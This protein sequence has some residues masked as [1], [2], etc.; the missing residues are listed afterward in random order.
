M[1][2]LRVRLVVLWLLSLAVSVAAAL[3]LVR[4]STQSV[5]A[6]VA[7]GEAIVARAC[8]L[9]R[10]RY[11]FYST[12]W[13]GPVPPPDDPAL[14]Q[15]LGAVVAVALARQP[16]VAGGVW[17]SEAGP[18]TA[19]RLPR[20]RPRAWGER[21]LRARAEGTPAADPASGVSAGDAAA[22]GT[23]AGNTAAGDVPGGPA[24][25]AAGAPP[26][27]GTGT[28]L[29]EAWL[30]SAA[31][32]AL[33]EDTTVARSWRA[34]GATRLLAACPLPGPI[35]G[36]TAW[37]LTDAEGVEAD[38]GLQ[39]GLAALLAVMLLLSVW[40]FWLLRDWS[41]RVG[42]VEAALTAGDDRLALPLPGE[43]DLDRIV[44]ALNR[45]G[46]RL[47]EARARSEALRRQVAESERL[48]ALGRVA[49]GLAH[50]IR[51][52]LAAMRLKAE[53][54]LAG[55]EARRV[56]ALGDVLAQVGRL[57][58]LLR[59]LLAM[60]QRHEPVPEIVQLD[61]L[62]ASCAEAHAE[63]AA[64]AGVALRHEGSGTAR[65]DPA[66]LRRAV[67]S[68]LD[69]AVRHTAVGGT[70]SL[71]AGWRDGTLAIAVE[72]TVAPGA[73]GV[74][75]SL[76]D[77]LFEPFVTGRP[78]GTGLGLAIA[79]ELVAAQRG[80]LLLDDPGGAGHPTRFLILLPEATTPSPTPSPDTAAWP[81]S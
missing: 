21:W 17:Q 6:Q 10:D 72:N 66:L 77:T 50:E 15:S 67:D 62:L 70:V 46:A 19:I 78:E 32:A 4:A 75:P 60:T 61:A 29:T 73:P 35:T 31:G 51:N 27:D 41:R 45:A 8:D 24:G 74:D 20:R 58:T 1:N 59:E 7:R 76:R 81:P 48:A 44:G 68:L 9:I 52:P 63:R 54:A 14:Q 38:H 37:A 26:T 3:L 64:A 18:L 34:D 42:R 33:R 23:P 2:A 53:N 49:A 5:E 79:R 47:A 12:D 40:V 30:R 11:G 25:G 39:L 16:G 43:R 55:D 65:L 13:S 22:P 71:L 80:R 36:L 57:D 28:S 56:R 69:N